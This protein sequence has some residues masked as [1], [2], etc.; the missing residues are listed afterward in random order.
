MSRF[1]ILICYFLF[2][3]TAK[4]IKAARSDFYQ[5][6]CTL[7]NDGYA[8]YVNNNRYAVVFPVKQAIFQ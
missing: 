6:F 1:S 3:G 2:Y 7:L 5:I 4:Y 8:T